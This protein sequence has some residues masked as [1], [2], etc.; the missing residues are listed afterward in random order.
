[1]EG[2]LVP[3]SD[4]AERLLK[5]AYLAEGREL[6]RESDG[7]PEELGTNQMLLLLVHLKVCQSH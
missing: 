2:Y 1:M 3:P 4:L 5:T 6:R 7:V